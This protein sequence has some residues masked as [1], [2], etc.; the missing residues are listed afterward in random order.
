MRC[1][2]LTRGRLRIRLGCGGVWVKSDFYPAPSRGVAGSFRDGQVLGGLCREVLGSSRTRGFNNRKLAWQA[3]EIGRLVIVISKFLRLWILPP[4]IT[5]ALW[6]FRVWC[7]TVG[8]KKAPDPHPTDGWE[9][10]RAAVQDCEK[11]AEYGCGES[12]LYMNGLSG[13][14][15]QVA[16]TDFGWAQNIEARTDERV[17]IFFVDLGKVGEWGR[18]VG[19]ENR[20]AFGTYFAAPFSG[21][22][23]PDVVLIDGRFRVACFLYALIHAKP[24]TVIVFDD[25]ANRPSYH[26]VEEIIAPLEVDQR[27][28]KFVRPSG[29]LSKAAAALL[30]KF[31]FVMD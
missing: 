21:G 13:C 25:Y 19:Y 16:E 31:E 10:F 27:Q 4:Q 14:N 26:V 15:I 29:E 8:Q 11:Y 3:E 24:G 23:S 18:P 12:T 20:A 17:K 9:I 22:F 6:T 30:E 1:L 7:K 28:A 5:V 2:L